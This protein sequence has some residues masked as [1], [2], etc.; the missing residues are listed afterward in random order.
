MGD[1]LL[2]KTYVHLV[3]DDNTANL[4]R[5][6]LLVLGRN[7]EVIAVSDA[8]A[9]GPLTDVDEGARSRFEWWARLGVQDLQE[10]ENYVDD[11]AIWDALRTD[12]R[13][14]M[15][16]SSAHPDEH[17][18]ALRACWHLRDYPTRIHEVVMTNK[19]YPRVSD[20]FARLGIMGPKAGV[21]HWSDRS[22]IVDVKERANRWEAIRSREGD[23]L[24]ELRDGQIVHLGVDA[25]DE[26]LVMACSKDWTDSIRAVGGVIAEL[27]V[28]LSL[29]TWRIHT[30]VRDG[31]LEARG[32]T[33]RLGMPSEL[34]AKGVT[35]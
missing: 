5:E 21:A 4:L 34:K 11:R 2:D 15:L 6:T 28:G 31:V 32:P 19:L 25:H 27:P 29:L 23:W 18:F 13:D 9:M 1:E 8:L 33:N 30:L 7:E 3:V 17:L 10:L 12:P 16:W 35:A 26:K 24:R 20:A 22:R 14:V